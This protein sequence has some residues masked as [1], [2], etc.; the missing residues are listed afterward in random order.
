MTEG[1]CEYRG[2][3]SILG[4]RRR[5][6][7]NDAEYADPTDADADADLILILIW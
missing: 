2:S 7:K 6:N 4:D 3:E 1:A 5:L